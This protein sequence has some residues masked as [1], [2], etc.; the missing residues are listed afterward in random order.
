MVEPGDDHVFE[1]HSATP[2]AP[3]FVHL[4]EP[5]P[6]INDASILVRLMTHIA[7]FLEVFDVPFDSLG[8]FFH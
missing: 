7:V 8:N 2:K 6:D 4:G 1:P 3:P 5:L